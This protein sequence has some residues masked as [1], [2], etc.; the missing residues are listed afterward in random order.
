MIIII[1]GNVLC[2][3]HTGAVHKKKRNKKK[4]NYFRKKKRS[5]INNLLW[6]KTLVKDD[7]TPTS[8]RCKYISGDHNSFPKGIT[9]IMSN[10][11]NG[12][13]HLTFSAL[14]IIIF[15]DIKMKT[16][17]L[18][19]QQ[20]RA[21]SDYTDVQAGLALIYWWQRLPTF[22]VD[23]IRVNKMAKFFSKLQYWDIS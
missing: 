19:S 1:P 5:K 8:P 21:C 20:Y 7:C 22:G 14:S 13:I 9:L 16:W 3:Y 12:I 11:L 17:K 10:F 18:V 15:R 2:I 4:E 6:L 23:R